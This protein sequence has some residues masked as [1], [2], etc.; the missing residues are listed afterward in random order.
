MT[1]LRTCRTCDQELPVT[2]FWKQANRSDGLFAEC[3]ACNTSRQRAW[4]DGNREQYQRANQRASRKMR[5]A[6]PRKQLLVYTR[7]RS[8][9]R[10]L[11]FTITEDDVVIPAVCPILGIELRSTFGSGG[12]P[13]GDAGSPSIDRIDNQRGYVPGNIVIVSWRANRIKSDATLAELKALVRFY[14]QLDADQDGQASLP[15]VQSH[16]KEEEGTMSIGIAD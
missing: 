11:D 14:E 4:V 7:R 12:K 3:K 13:G 15:A 5:S 8:L 16:Q 9:A 6:D 10:G 2:A 1:G